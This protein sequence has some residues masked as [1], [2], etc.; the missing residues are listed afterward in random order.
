MSLPAL[1]VAAL[2][3]GLSIGA[4][5]AWQVQAWRR[6]AAEL[7]RQRTEA[8]DDAR[9]AEHADSAATTYETQRAAGQAAARVIVREVERV[10]EA[11]VYRDVCLDDA[12][13]QLVAR[14]IDAA[15]DPGQPAPAVPAASAPR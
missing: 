6:D 12:G 10:V 9:R 8:R 3:V 7:Q 5:G 11:P 13:L 4:A 14:A 1:I 2:L 15:A